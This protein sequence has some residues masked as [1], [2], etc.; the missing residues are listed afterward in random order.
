VPTLPM[1]LPEFIVLTGACGGLG[2]ECARLL[3]LAGSTVIGIDL[4]QPLDELTDRGTYHHV[5]GSI[6][7]EATWTAA[8]EALHFCGWSPSKTLGLL[9][10]AAILDVGVLLEEDLQIW[11]RT[12]R[13]N[14]L[15]HVLGMRSLL[16]SLT[17]AA[18]G[19]I[20]MVTSVDARFAEQQ[21]A[22]YASSKAA[23]EMA[24]RT[25]A[26]DYARTGVNIN[27]L[28]PGPMRAGLFERHLASSN[29]PERFLATRTSRQPI[30][31]IVEAREVA[32]AVAFLLSDRAS[33]IFGAV[34]TVDGGLTAG[35]DFRSGDEGSSVHH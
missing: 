21:L 12:W 19:S 15:G 8:L 33:A 18:R 3:T 11:E 22:A 32:S 14:T 28:A 9:G 2:E 17:Q 31:R 34:V 23:L 5:L 35:F 27:V 7:D 20:V 30:G 26:L 10:V 24:V 16:P 6:T 13:V 25:V 4:G 1:D 29:D